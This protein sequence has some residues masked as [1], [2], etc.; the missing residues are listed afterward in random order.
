MFV[1]FGLNMVAN[2]QLLF[3][4]LTDRKHILNYFMLFDWKEAG[5]TGKGS[6]YIYINNLNKKKSQQTNHKL[7]IAA[8]Q[9]NS[10]NKTEGHTGNYSKPCDAAVISRGGIISRYNHICWLILKGIM[11]DWRSTLLLIRNV[12]V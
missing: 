5:V 7:K 10:S 3:G 11:N 1:P 4:H 9:L 2:I 12:L 6:Q 8:G